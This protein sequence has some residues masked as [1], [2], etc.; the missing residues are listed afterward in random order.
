MKSE[1]LARLPYRSSGRAFCETAF[2][3][4]ADGL[5][6]GINTRFI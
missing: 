2:L 5:I 3:V 4:Y 6:D 1:D